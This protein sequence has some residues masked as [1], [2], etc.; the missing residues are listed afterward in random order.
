M[1]DKNIITG[2]KEDTKHVWD[3]NANY[4]PAGTKT[5]GDCNRKLIDTENDFFNLNKTT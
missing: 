2:K 3:T 1:K 4:V 5:T